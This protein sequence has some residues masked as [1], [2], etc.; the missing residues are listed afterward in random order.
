MKVIHQALTINVETHIRFNCFRKTFCEENANI[1]VHCSM[2]FEKVSL[3][4]TEHENTIYIVKA[5]FVRD[6]YDISYNIT[7]RVYLLHKQTI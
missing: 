1:F 6:L 4:M 3:K 7:F 5:C 2:I